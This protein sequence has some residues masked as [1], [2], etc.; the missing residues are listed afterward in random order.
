MISKS[1][2]YGSLLYR[3]ILN[4][5]SCGF[6]S[7]FP[8]QWTISERYRLHKC[9]AVQYVY[10]SWYIHFQQFFLYRQKLPYRR[11]Y[12]FLNTVSYICRARQTGT[13]TGLQVCR[14]VYSLSSTWQNFDRHPGMKKVVGGYC[15]HTTFSKCNSHLLEFR[16]IHEVDDSGP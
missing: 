2:S 15:L 6:I 13:N 11:A 9:V 5:I 1:N 14:Y 8:C 16:Y 4:V 3:G 7:L 10:P 12:Q